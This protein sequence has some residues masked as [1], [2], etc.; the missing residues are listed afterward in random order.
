MGTDARTPSQ[1]IHRAKWKVLGLLAMRMKKVLELGF[2]GREARGMVNGFMSRNLPCMACDEGLNVSVDYSKLKVSAGELQA[3]E[4]T[5]QWADSDGTLIF[6]QKRQPLKPLMYDDDR[7][8]VFLWN[9]EVLRTNLLP[10]HQRKETAEV[11]FTLEEW[12]NTSSYIRCCKIVLRGVE[13]LWRE[14]YENKDDIYIHVYCSSVRLRYSCWGR[15]CFCHLPF[16][17][18][19]GTLLRKKLYYSLNRHTG[20]AFQKAR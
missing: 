19:G 6:K 1:L 10:L 14:T 18:D 15:G 7:F 16:F 11:C 2:P 17:T 5:A 12:K 13:K 9:P 3:P 20:Q 4:V 8:Y